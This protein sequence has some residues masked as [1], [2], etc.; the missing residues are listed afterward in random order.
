[1]TDDDPNRVAAAWE[2]VAAAAESV[3]RRSWWFSLD[4]VCEQLG[5]DADRVRAQAA[6]RRGETREAGDDV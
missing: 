5:V 1:M 6:K 4:E 2:V 3:A